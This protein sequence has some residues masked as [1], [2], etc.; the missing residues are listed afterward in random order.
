M[1]SPFRVWLATRYRQARAA[2]LAM[3]SPLP[4]LVWAVAS[5]VLGRSFTALSPGPYDAQLF[6]YIGLQWLHGR[7]PYL[8]VWEHKPPGIFA[9]D[10]FVFS[11]FPKDFT[12]L[13][14]VEGIFV[15]GC[16]ATVYLLLLHW[17]APRLV[18]SLSGGAAAIACNL[19][20][21]NELGNLTEVYLLWPATLSMYCF[22]RSGARFERRWVFM[23]G[24]LSGVAS[25]FKPVGLAP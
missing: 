16:V 9:V 8:Q 4:L 7:I 19:E 24:F 23:A 18:A 3:N 10:A 5:T 13:A 12:A 25:L 11:A 22:T 14:V 2:G 1:G 21:F 20:A 15:L 17:G 6:A